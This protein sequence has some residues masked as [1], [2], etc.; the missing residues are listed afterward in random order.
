MID[1]MRLNKFLRIRKRKT[2]LQ[3]EVRDNMIPLTSIRKRSLWRRKN[4]QR[5]RLQ[6]HLLKKMRMVIKKRKRMMKRTMKY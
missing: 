3:E 6:S 2:Y 4:L 1:R 5:K